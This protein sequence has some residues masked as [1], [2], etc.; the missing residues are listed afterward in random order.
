MTALRQ[1]RRVTMRDDNVIKRQVA[2]EQEIN[3]ALSDLLQEHDFVPC[4]PV[5]DAPYDLT[6]GL[7]DHKLVLE[8][9]AVDGEQVQRMMLGLQ[10]LRPLIR[11]YFM[12]CENYYA[13]VHSPNRTQLEAIDAGR[14]GIHNEA[15]QMLLDMLRDKVR[16]DHCTARRLFTLVAALHLGGWSNRS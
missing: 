7:E 4:Q 13:A 11:D 10:P 1:L 14:R 9:T 12:I 3:A 8:L 15:A 5:G 2:I 16:L 6:L